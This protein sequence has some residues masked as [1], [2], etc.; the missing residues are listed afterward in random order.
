[1]ARVIM[2]CDIWD[3]ERTKDAAGSYMHPTQKADRTLCL[4]GYK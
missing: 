4:E 3:I 1:M 2:V